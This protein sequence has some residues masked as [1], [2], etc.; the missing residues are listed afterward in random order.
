M[1]A[2]DASSLEG[3]A[4]KQSLRP[5]NR[6]TIWTRPN[7]AFRHLSRP[8]ANLSSVPNAS[9]A[10]PTMS[11]GCLG[12]AERLDPHKAPDERPLP[13]QSGVQLLLLLL[14]QAIAFARISHASSPPAASRDT[15]TFSVHHARCTTS[16]RR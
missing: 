10:N 11:R 15:F 2:P 16:C 5:R 3:S 14:E 7:L 6:A 9:P 12:R 4:N 8:G 1:H 13:S